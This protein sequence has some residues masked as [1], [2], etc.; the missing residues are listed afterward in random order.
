MIIHWKDVTECV[1]E[2]RRQVLA[3]GN[4]HSRF[5]T[6]PGKSQFL[7]VTK[8]N[9]SRTGGSWDCEQVHW[10][11]PF[12]VVVTH[13]SEITGPLAEINDDA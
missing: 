1:P 2:N 6:S 4:V 10:L 13:W 12:G 11:S 5:T 7:G 8:F 9:P 3:W